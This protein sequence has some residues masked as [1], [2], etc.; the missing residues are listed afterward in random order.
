M[1]KFPFL[2][3]VL[4]LSLLAQCVLLP[5]S[6][7]EDPT[8]DTEE[9]AQAT[10]DTQTAEVAVFGTVC[11]ESGCRTIDGM[12]SLAGNTSVIDTA[13]SAFLYETETQTVVYSYNPDM[14]VD[15]GALAKLV[16][17]VVVAQN[18]E[19]DEIVTVT[20]D[21][22]NLPSGALHVG[23]KADEEIS[24]EDLLYCLVLQTANDAAIALA[25]HV[26][27]NQ[28][29][30]L[31]LM[32]QWVK[33]IGCTDTE[34]A[35]ITGLSTADSTTTARDM[36]RIMQAASE[37]EVVQKIMATTDY[38]VEA[39]NKNEA[40][41]F[42]TLN[43]MIDNGTISDFRD[44]RVT[45]GMQSYMAEY[46]A[47]LVVT[48][49][50]T[51]ESMH[52]VGVIMGAERTVAENGWS[53]TSYGNFNEMTD[54]LKLGFN[55]YKVNRIV[56]E[57]MA[58]NQFVV[59]GGECDVVG[60]AH[61][62]IDSV[63]P[64]SAQMGN[65]YTNYTVVDTLTAPIEQGQLIA[66]VQVKYRDCVLTEAEVYAM[67]TVTVS[68]SNGVTVRSTAVRSDSDS[69]GILSVIGTICV[70]ILGLAAVY[71]AFNA[72]MRS[73]AR[74]RRRKRREGRRRNF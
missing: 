63:V 70:I 29:G 6:A 5:V 3:L 68:G 11:I 73:R 34:F 54:L 33:S 2:C 7:T 38:T 10:E 15:P 65:L 41:S 22:N 53:V 12:V 16:V 46:G 47:S 67:N 42:R 72:Y 26:S 4:C 52:F 40:Y 49:T 45:G 24:V 18:C 62:N 71:L 14:A 37:N 19:L 9:Q 51:D 59:S 50:S 13:L 74:A 66:T 48:A 1:K 32:N 30:F 60:E 56:Y 20:S 64:S 23:L 69:S 31:T 8:E 39:T 43:Y 36:A 55:N 21:V 61:V 25:D 27:G 57:G 17:A 28:Q 44:T 35:N 58:M